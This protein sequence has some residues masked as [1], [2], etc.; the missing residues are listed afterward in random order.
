MFY[1][2]GCFRFRTLQGDYFPTLVVVSEH[3]IFNWFGNNILGRDY[4]FNDDSAD[5]LFGRF[6]SCIENK[7]LCILNEA[8]GKDTFTINEKIKNAITRN[9]NTIEKK[10]A[11]PYDNTNNIGYIFLTNNDNPLKIPHDDRRFTGI[12]CNF[13][14]AND[15]DY[16]SKLYGEINSKK[17]DKAFY[18]YFINVD[19]TDYNFTNERPIT[20]FYNNMKE[21]NTPVLTRFFEHIVNDNKIYHFTSTELFNKFN[22]F[23]KSNNFKVEYTS[24][25]FGIEI[26]SY[27]GI[28]KK[29]SKNGMIIDV[30]IDK[31]KSYLINKYKL[32][33]YNELKTISDNF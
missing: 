7:I 13:K 18:D 26:K 20:S 8:S 15:K 31:L 14:Y 2:R 1:R 6:N 28:E 24:T 27:E 29:R 16:F 5:L 19:L 23:V 9:I 3:T 22:E 10:G 12:E 25:K 4:Y 11:T 30:D 17:Y 21:L 33:F 32:E